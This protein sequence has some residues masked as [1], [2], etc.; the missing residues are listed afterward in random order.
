MN[1][2]SPSMQKDLESFQRLSF[3][4]RANITPSFYFQDVWQTTNHHA[5]GSVHSIDDEEDGILPPHHARQKDALAAWAEMTAS[6][7]RLSKE[8]DFLLKAQSQHVQALMACKPPIKAPIDNIEQK[9]MPQQVPSSK[10]K[11]VKVKKIRPVNQGHQEIVQISDAGPPP[12]D[13]TMDDD[14][15]WEFYESHEKKAR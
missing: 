3:F 1:N 9:K 6:Q 13:D 2:R 11:K 4:L 12:E 15:F 5:Y 8:W 14:A 10:Q 7:T